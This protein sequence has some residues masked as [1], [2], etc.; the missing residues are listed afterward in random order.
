MLPG[1]L[2]G[3][4]PFAATRADEHLFN[5]MRGWALTRTR[6]W[7]SALGVSGRPPPA[8]PSRRALLLP[9]VPTPWV[10]MTPLPHCRPVAPALPTAILLSGGV[11]SGCWESSPGPCRR[12]AMLGTVA[13]GTPAG[14]GAL[15]LSL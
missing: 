3:V 7:P 11:C 15:Y 10:S 8:A 13:W 2:Y 5:Q 12:L 4:S 14:S 6:P 9:C 1:L